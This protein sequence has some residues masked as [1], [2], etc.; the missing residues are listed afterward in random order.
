MHVY[1]GS[2]NLNKYILSIYLFCAYPTTM[3]FNDHIMF[4]H[5][6]KQFTWLIYASILQ[7]CLPRKMLPLDLHCLTKS[8]LLWWMPIA[9]PKA[10]IQQLSDDQSRGNSW[11]LRVTQFSDDHM[12]WNGRASRKK[13]ERHCVQMKAWNGWFWSTQHRHSAFSTYHHSRSNGCVG[14]YT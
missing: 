5:P 8:F 6:V 14:L 2:C 1:Q 7:A 9:Y 11:E 3:A 4:R 13:L 12:K 10:L